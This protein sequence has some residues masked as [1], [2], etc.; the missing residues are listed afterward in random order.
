MATRNQ[1]GRLTVVALVEDDLAATKDPPSRRSQDL[2][3][4]SGGQSRE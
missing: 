2:F 4:L 3:C 1:M